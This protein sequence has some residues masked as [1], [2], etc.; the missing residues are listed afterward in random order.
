[1]NI[2]NVAI[3]EPLFNALIALYRFLPGHDLGVAIIILTI[4]IKFL[5]YAP[6]LATIKNQRSQQEMQP[7]LAEIRKKY[8][9]DKQE[10]GRQ[11]MALYKEH[12]SNPFS[13]CLPLLIQLPI[14]WGLYQVFFNGLHLDANGLLVPGQVQHLYDGL[15]SVYST[16]PVSTM[17]L[18]F[19]NLAARKNY[20]LAI[21]AGIFQYLQSRRLMQRQPPKTEG[22]RDEQ[23]AAVM[24]QQTTYLFPVITVIIGISFPAGLT[25]YWII[26]TLFTIIQQELYFR[27]HPMPS[28]SNAVIKNP[29][30]PSA[31]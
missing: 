8:A 6:S 28:V 4:G 10:M 7:K 15:R 2:F 18:G 24:S 21:L 16:T 11:I 12:R 22:S 3:Y 17:F 31:R 13:A 5:L 20:S 14:L 23:F 9:N 25:L 29:T 27:N 1:M 30:P 26:S 19:I